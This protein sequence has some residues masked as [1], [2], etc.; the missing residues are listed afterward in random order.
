MDFTSALYLGLQHPSRSLEFEEL[1]TGAPAALRPLPATQAAEAGFAELVGCERAL[2]LPSTLHA[3]C[4]LFAQ[5][6]ARPAVLLHDAGVYP[7]A[8]WGMERVQ[9][10]GGSVL[11]FRHHDAGH[12]QQR[13]SGLRAGSANVWVVCDGFCAGCGRSAPLADYARLA[14]GSG[15]RL[16]VDDTQALGLYG[17]APAALPPY[18]SGGGGSLVRWAL[19]RAGVIV[20]ASL[21]K[22]LGAPLAMLAGPRP[23]VEAFARESD[24]LVHCSPPSGADVAAARAAIAWNARHGDARRARLAAAVAT[25]RRALQR[26]GLR[27]GGGSFPVQRLLM[28]SSRAAQTLSAALARRGID[29]VVQRSRCTRQS[30]VTFIIN[31]RHGAAELQDAVLALAA[32]ARGA[33]QPFNLTKRSGGM[34]CW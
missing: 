7:I 26:Q 22:A 3:F 29:T 31:A 28:P 4:D 20:V 10:R 21:A 9:G 34:S 6:A 2:A 33:P 14:Q 5:I 19:P 11:P 8:R 1:T 23:W 30:S 13:L 24:T 32:A 18:G 27:A 12:L 16:L 25:F 17:R 15:A